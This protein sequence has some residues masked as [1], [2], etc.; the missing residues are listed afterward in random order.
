MHVL[1]IGAGIAGVAA[2]WSA[3]QRGAE[4]TLLDGGVSASEL[5]GGAV[6]DV[7]WEELERAEQASGTLLNTS[8][9]SKPAALFVAALD[10]WHMVPTGAP[11][12]RIIS[13][14]GRTRLTRG[15]DHGLLDL[16][17]LRDGSRIMLPRVPRPEWDADS[18][19]HCL[20][21]APY[22]RR[23]KLTFFAAD[24]S[25]LR[26][27]GDDCVP[28]ACLAELY[29]EDPSWLMARLMESRAA[30]PG[31]EAILCGPW[32]GAEIAM[33]P[34][35]SAQLKLP[36]GEAF[37]GLDSPYALRFRQARKRLVSAAGI[38]L[39]SD[40]ASRI[41]PQLDVQ[42]VTLQHGADMRA[43]HIVLAVGG[44]TGGG[45]VYQPAFTHDGI[46]FPPSGKCPFRLSLAVPATLMAYGKPL[47]VTSSVHGPNLDNLAWPKDADPGLLEAVGISTGASGIGALRLAPAVWAA[48]DVL[49]DRQRTIVAAVESGLRAGW[50]AA[51]THGS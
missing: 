43:D 31:A 24:A 10:L 37:S 7:P 47:R 15:Y 14:A 30:H 9:L 18:L 5:S 4:V 45:L 16:E 2:A 3:A 38:R 32:L 35:L 33:A 20:T 6:D 42:C 46:D 49:A 50:A 44:L 25:L 29:A 41:E 12:A 27:I 17:Q 48:G 36:I 28:S 8:A 51:A 13:L 22:A 23:R 1:V 19:A 34:S 26:H 39:L 21:S 11:F 40:R